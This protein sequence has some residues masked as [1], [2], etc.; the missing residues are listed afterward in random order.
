MARGRSRLAGTRAFTFR[1]AGPAPP[2][3]AQEVVCDS[4]VA[5]PVFF[6]SIRFSAGISRRCS[7]TDLLQLARHAVFSHQSQNLRVQ[8]ECPG[9]ASLVH[10]YPGPKHVSRR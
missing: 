5:P 4:G 7:R 10:A 3:A 8:A 1:I 2:L 9:E 6:L